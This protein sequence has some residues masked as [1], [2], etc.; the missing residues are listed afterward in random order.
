MTIS[1]RGLKERGDTKRPP[2]D[3]KEAVRGLK[4]RRNFGLQI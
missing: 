1:L 4:G 3:L 2:E